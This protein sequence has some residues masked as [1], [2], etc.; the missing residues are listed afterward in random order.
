MIVSAKYVGKNA[1]SQTSLTPDYEHVDWPALAVHIST[2][3]PKASALVHRLA[4]Q[5]TAPFMT[6]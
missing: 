5:E 3:T 2:V 1:P 6:G 4:Q